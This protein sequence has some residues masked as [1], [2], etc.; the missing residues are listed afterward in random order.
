MSADLRVIVITGTMGSGKTTVLAE[1]SDILTA[2]GLMHAAIDLDALG[3]AYVPDNPL[4]DLA[5][6]NLSSLWKT[7][8]ALGV[9]RLLVAGAIE[10]LAE[11][12][13]IRAAVP[14]SAIVTC[15]LTAKLETMQRRVSV[16]EPGMLHDKL[17]ARVSEL[18]TVLDGARL[19]DFSLSND[20]RSVTDVATDLLTRAGWI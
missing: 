8:G 20:A 14:D 9:T 15:R 1:A 19:E 7:Y 5:Y 10:N 3:I 13:R 2:R 17:V 18:E 6:R 11:L 16:R 4:I 12:N